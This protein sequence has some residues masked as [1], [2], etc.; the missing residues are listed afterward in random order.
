MR[1][2]KSFA[3]SALSAAACVLLPVLLLSA[4][5]STPQKPVPA[6]TADAG[7]ENNEP[8]L[9]AQLRARMASGPI[10]RQEKT[11][12]R[13]PTKAAVDTSQS[14]A[15]L[16]D[17]AKQQAVMAV[18]GDYAKALGLMNANK[19]EEAL[20]LLQKVA[21]KAPKLSGPLVN[22]AVILLK[23]EK[24]AEADTILQAALQANPKNPYAFNLKGQVLR[25]QGKFADAKA[26]YESALA[27]DPN[28]AKA[29]FNYGVLADLYMQD[30]PL[31]LSHYERY[32]SLQSRP[33]TAVA[34][35][36]IDLQK[37][38]GVYKAPAP[39]PIAAPTVQDASEEA[40]APTAE[41]AAP[42]AAEASAPATTEAG[43]APVAP[44]STGLANPE[45]K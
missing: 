26:A 8:D 30:L 7:A 15:M 13:L 31:A 9:V 20:I 4:C 10:Q 16:M 37:R 28:Y 40:A 32:Q 44:V 43:A 17:A 3:P 23:Q 34:N 5:T 39:T 12:D 21:V 19:D 18:A 2:K 11:E 27:I 6:E 22:Q 35:W 33:D 29:H 45:I 14:P 36:I 42:L 25:G 41:N 38:T 24:F 1:L